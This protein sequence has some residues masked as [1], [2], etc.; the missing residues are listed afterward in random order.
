MNRMNRMRD[1]NRDYIDEESHNF[2]YVSLS[3]L[4]NLFHSP[5]RRLSMSLFDD[6]DGGIF[7]TSIRIY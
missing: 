1:D 7:P 3:Q 6:D 5:L 2:F 4:K